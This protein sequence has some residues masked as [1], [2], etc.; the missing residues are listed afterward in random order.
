M[1]YF[2]LVLLSFM[3]VAQPG[4]AETTEFNLHISSDRVDVEKTLLLSD[5]GEG[6]T[7][8]N[9]DFQDDTGQQY[10]FKLD[11]VE[12]PSNRSYPTNLDITLMDSTGEKLGYLFWANNGVASLKR[13][14]TFGFVVNIDG[15][16]TDVRFEF[17]KLM[18]GSLQVADLANERFVQDTLVSKY[19]F[20]MIRPVTL[21]LAE[22]GVRSQSYRLDDHPFE[23]NYTLKDL[24]SG[25]VEFQFNLYQSEGDDKSL[26]ERVY[27]H[28]A[29]LDTLR[30][31]MFA[32]KYFDQAAGTIKL[33]YYPAMGQTTPPNL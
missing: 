26:L 1:N 20:Q 5:V 14:G 31:G 2:P 22:S 28:A 6:A 27:Y 18:K 24:D 15:I 19:G 21:P 4:F 30:E 12:L 9:F 23:V 33:V 25:S 10:S 32:G 11:Y 16:P 17:D 3:A 13:T 29:T 7:S 8:I